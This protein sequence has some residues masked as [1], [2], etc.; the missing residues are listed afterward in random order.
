MTP[1]NRAQLSERMLMMWQTRRSELAEKMSVGKKAQWAEWKADPKKMKEVTK[2]MTKSARAVA[3]KFAPARKEAARLRAK[4]KADLKVF[5][6]E[7]NAN[8]IRYATHLRGFMTSTKGRL[9]SRAHL[10]GIRELVAEGI[11]EVDLKHRNKAH[12]KYT[13]PNLGT[14]EFIHTLRGEDNALC[15]RIKEHHD[16][17]RQKRTL[18]VGV[19][20]KRLDALEDDTKRRAE[21]A[22]QLQDLSGAE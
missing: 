10:D 1:E 9:V 14:L 5:E 20:Q 18:R 4:E 21:I 2:R 7:L 17:L 11:F 15:I 22:K 16:Y 19:K 3:K 8:F 12:H 6:R 13:K